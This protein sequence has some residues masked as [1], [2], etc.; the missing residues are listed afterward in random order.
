MMSPRQTM[1]SIPYWW[2]Q[3]I[4]TFIASKL[5]WRSEITPIFSGSA[6]GRILP[7]RRLGQASADLLH[8]AADLLRPGRARGEAQEPLVV[9]QGLLEPAQ[10][11]PRDPAVHARPGVV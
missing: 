8:L 7:R 2:S 10:L 6:M 3:F 1:W 4:T 5:L 9:G 11:G